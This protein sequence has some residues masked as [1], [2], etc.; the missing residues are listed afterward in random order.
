MTSSTARSMSAPDRIK[1]TQPEAEP[2]KGWLHSVET[3]GMADGP[4]VRFIAFLTGCPLRCQYCHNPD[5]LHKKDGQE[6]TSDA[7]LAE[8]ASYASFLKQSGGGVTVSGGEPLAQAEFT[9]IILQ[10]CKD[11]GLHTALD[12]SGYLGQR[13]DQD[14]LEATDLVLLD[15]K[16]GLPATYKEVTGRDLK[17]TLDFARVLSN[18]GKPMWL[19]FVLV[20]G[21]TDAHE[22][23]EAVADFAATLETVERID[24]LPF[25]KMGEHKWQRLGLTYHLEGTQT[26]EAGDVARAKALFEARGLNAI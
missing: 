12:T 11:M 24:I 8:I 18:L 20:P 6:V 13:A 17:P 5:M 21:L 16:S 7:L 19:R 26:P 4:G 3:G 23:I 25:H 22:N 14:I 1:A 9:K 15:I 2:V 10:G